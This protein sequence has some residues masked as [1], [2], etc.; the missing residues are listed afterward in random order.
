[1]VKLSAPYLITLVACRRTSGGGFIILH[2]QRII[3]LDVKSR[4]ASMYTKAQRLAE[5]LAQTLAK[6]FVNGTGWG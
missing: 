2:K 1:M 6:A 3:D 4:L 5:A